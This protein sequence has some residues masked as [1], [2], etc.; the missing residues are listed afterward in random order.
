MVPEVV[1]GEPVTDNPVVPGLNATEVTVPL[2]PPDTAAQLTLDPSVLRTLPEL[3]DCTGRRLLIAVP[4]FVAPVPPLVTSSLPP[5]VMVP[6]LVIGLLLKVR[7]VVPPDTPTEVTALAHEV[8]V[9]SVV[10]NLPELVVC[11]GA[12][13]LNAAV[14]VVSPVPPLAIF[15]LPVMAIVPL[16]VTGLPVIVIPDKAVVTATEVTVPPPAV[17]QD[18]L[19]PSVVK[20]LAF[21]PV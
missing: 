4:A 5:I 6:L 16:E 17:P 10:K 2:P 12:S 18:T 3:P 14:A 13:A 8:L 11:E 20:N 7:P 19:V 21:C 9:P 1:I 15:S